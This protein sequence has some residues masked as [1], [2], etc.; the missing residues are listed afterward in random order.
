MRFD[1]AHLPAN[2]RPYTAEEIAPLRRDPLIAASKVR[3]EIL[4]EVAPAY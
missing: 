3:A 2:F 4:G 1:A